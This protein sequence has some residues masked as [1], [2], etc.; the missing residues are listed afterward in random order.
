[1]SPIL[2]RPVRE[3]LEHDRVIRL[4]QQDLAKKKVDVG[5]NPGAEQNAS[6]GGAGRKEFPDAVLYSTEKGRKLIGVVEVETAESI[7]HLE[8]MS[9]W[10]HLA[11]L[12]VPF[13]LYVPTGSG[14]AARRLSDD[15]RIPVTEIW[16][17]HQVGEQFKFTLIYPPA[18][19]RSAPTAPRMVSVASIRV[20]PRVDPTAGEIH[21]EAPAKSAPQ[22]KS[23]PQ[24]KSVPPIQAMPGA[25]STASAA[26]VASE[27]A[28]PRVIPARPRVIPA[29]TAVAAAVAKPAASKPAAGK[30]SPAAPVKTSPPVAKAPAKVATVPAPKVAPAKV[31]PAKVAPAKVVAAKSVAAKKVVAAKAVTSAARAERRPPAGRPAAAPRK[32]AP[33]RK[34]AARPPAA[35]RVSKSKLPSV[36]KPA[37][38]RR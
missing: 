11:K 27:P 24:T 14:D 10:A 37:P 26:K 16:S 20:E 4:L 32:P 7:N 13:H 38:K 9:Q 12:R 23:G 35:A 1:L 15:H 34:S 18:R 30:S 8:A 19:G 3:Q 5:I 17:Y 31:A 29:K 28:S 25:R 21:E 22:T 36:R 2:V 6:V 33:V